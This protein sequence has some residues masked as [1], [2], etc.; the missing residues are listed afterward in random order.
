MDLQKYIN[1]LFQSIKNKLSEWLSLEEGETILAGDIYRFLHSIKGTSGTL[2]LDKL[3]KLSEELLNQV[4]QDGEDWDIKELKPFLFP[5]IELT[6]QYENFEESLI[7]DE[8][9]FH[10]NAPLI[11][12]ID[13]DVSLLML[14]KDVLEEKDWIV[15]TYTNPEKAVNQYF[16]MQPDCLIL[17][18]QLPY[19]DGFQ[20]LQEIQ[21]HNEKHFIPTVMISIKNNKQ[22][23]IE[24]YQKGADDFFSKPIDIEEFVAKIDRHLKRKRIFDQSVLID[25]LTQVYNRKYLVDSL[26]RFFQ[27]FKRNKQVFSLCIVDIDLFKKINDTYGHFIGDRVL[28]DF[29]QYLQ[30]NI[31]SSDLLCRFGGEEFVIVFPNASNEEVKNRLNELMKGFS[32]IEFTHEGKSFSVTFSAGVFMVQDESVTMEEAF[33]RADSALYKAK[34]QGRARVECYQAEH[35]SYQKNV[36]NISVIDD[37]VII[38][39]VLGQMLQSLKMEHIEL[40]IKLFEDGPSF[41]QSQHAKEDVN[42]FLILDGVMPIMDG[43]EVLRNVKQGK[44][45]HRYNV[46]M[47]TGRKSKEE[48]EHALNLG[49]DDY[50]TKP[51]SIPELRKRIERMLKRM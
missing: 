28:K 50:V 49:A 42:H 21:E 37:D 6:Y 35:D 47:L 39:N 15:M 17:D 2:Q 20:V 51:F 3:M 31:R 24:A 11:Q 40:N 19:K 1:H 9:V 16:D 34:N 5:L 45:A 12:V 29:A 44:N 23:R 36:L 41:L 43:L 13:D 14:F 48:I 25:E 33:K 7:D 22:M 8:P 26:P 4:D 18:I 38:R 46:L 10:T 32:E 30:K 27:E